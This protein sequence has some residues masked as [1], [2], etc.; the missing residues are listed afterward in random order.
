MT[1][2]HPHLPSSFSLSLSLI[3]SLRARVRRKSLSLSHSLSHEKQI[4]LKKRYSRSVSKYVVCV[5]FVRWG[6]E[7]A[8]TVGTTLEKLIKSTQM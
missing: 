5:F 1:R 4:S 3:L 8:L 7:V 6:K 2:H